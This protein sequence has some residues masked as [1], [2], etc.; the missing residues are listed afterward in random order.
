MKQDDVSALSAQPA[1]PASGP[2]VGPDLRGRLGLIGLIELLQLVELGG[3]EARIELGAAGP[4]GGE[5]F[6]RGGALVSARCGH[7]DGPEALLALLRLRDGEFSLF[8]S[9]R[10]PSIS[11]EH[12][13]P[14]VSS[15]L[16]ESLRLED[17]LANHADTQLPAEHPL[18]LLAGGEFENCPAG[19]GTELLVHAIREKPGIT[20]AR[21]KGTLPLA[22]QRVDL[23]VAWMNAYGRLELTARP[24]QSARLGTISAVWLARLMDWKQGRLRL[25]VACPEGISAAELGHEVASLQR[26][27]RATPFTFESSVSGPSF[28]RLRPAVGGVL[29]ITFLPM[30]RRHRFLFQTFARGVDLALVPAELDDASRAEL[31]PDVRPEYVLSLPAP[32]CVDALSSA[33]KQFAGRLPSPMPPR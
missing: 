19:E 1:P 2:Q 22:P 5:V 23:A 9:R 3:H 20:Q 32:P 7:L 13:L 10:V 27:L 14:R 15:I 4:G 28:V 8:A 17:D 12:D 29:S 16:L 24:R 6:L 25:L 26:A 21:L 33:L 31:L 18:A 11:N 30:S